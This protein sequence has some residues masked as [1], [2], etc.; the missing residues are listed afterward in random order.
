MKKPFCLKRKKINFI[1][2]YN[3]HF[4]DVE[5]LQSHVA[6]SNDPIMNAAQKLIYKELGADDNYQSVLNVEKRRGA[7][8]SAVKNEPI[9]LLRDCSG[10][11]LLTFYSNGRIQICYI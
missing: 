11:W 6:W 4:D 9:L 5:I 1:G 8:Y 7:P 10:H 3:F 2:L